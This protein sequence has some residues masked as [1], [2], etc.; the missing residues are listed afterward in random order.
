MAAGRRERK[1]MR[2]R[3]GCFPPHKV[4]GST[5]SNGATYKYR[6]PITAQQILTRVEKHL[7]TNMHKAGSA[8]SSCTNGDR[9]RSSEMLEI[10]NLSYPTQTGDVTLITPEGWACNGAATQPRRTLAS[11][12]RESLCYL[13]F[14]NQEPTAQAA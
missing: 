6:C 7:C 3:S 4:L 2:K 12:V 5:A 14:P 8:W 9:M 1:I 13:S 10:A 11:V